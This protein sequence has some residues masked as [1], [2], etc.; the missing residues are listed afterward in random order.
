MVRVVLVLLTVGVTIYAVVDSL[1]CSD[2]E[3][4]SLPRS[5]WI[6]ISLVPLVGGVAWLL[7][8]RPRDDLVPEAGP[9]VI[10]PDDDPDF[11]NSLDQSFRERRRQAAEDRRHNR[12]EQAGA[13]QTRPAEQ[14][15][16]AEQPAAAEEAHRDEAHRRTDGE[17]GE[18]HPARP[19]D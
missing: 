10:A 8:G 17:D 15:H 5:V 11:L 13:E 9:R 14:A 7:L 2:D 18:E 6:L 12:V 19:A 1:R 3:V 16:A 4:R